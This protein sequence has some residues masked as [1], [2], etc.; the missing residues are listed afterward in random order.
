MMA[1]GRRR[2]LGSRQEKVVQR[3]LQG[4]QMSAHRHS[5]LWGALI[6]LRAEGVSPSQRGLELEPQRLQSLLG[7][8]IAERLDELHIDIDLA[9]AAQRILPRREA[10]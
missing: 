6:T 9:S 3:S 1:R 4:T 8:G 7:F 10:K 2:L 5:A